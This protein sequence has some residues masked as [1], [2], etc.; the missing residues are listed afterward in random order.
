MTWREPLSHDMWRQTW[1]AVGTSP[2]EATPGEHS[3]AHGAHEAVMHSAYRPQ[4]SR[5][6][7]DGA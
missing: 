7:R 2:G 6:D 4:S 1:Q 5:M 3:R